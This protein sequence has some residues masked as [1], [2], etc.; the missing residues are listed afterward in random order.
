MK[1]DGHACSPGRIVPPVPPGWACWEELMDRALVLADRARLLGEVPVGAL[2]LSPEGRIV[3]EGYNSPEAAC[4]ATAH[5]EMIAIRRA[6]AALGNYRLGGCILVVTLEP[7][8]MCAGAM[9]HARIAGVVYG[10]ADPLAGA[11]TSRLEG[12]DAAFL[13]HQVWHMGRIRE[14]DCARRLQDFFAQRRSRQMVPS[15]EM[16]PENDD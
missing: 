1:A 13:N 9:A 15:H 3:G 14:Q 6:C 10:A 12:L 4:D 2:V 11:V 8:L 16:S 7:C 5:A